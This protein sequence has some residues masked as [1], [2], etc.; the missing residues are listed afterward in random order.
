MDHAVRLGRR[1]HVLARPGAGELE[2]VAHDPV[3]AAAGEDASPGSRSLASVPSKLRPPTAEYSPSLFSR[4]TMKSMSPG[5]RSASGEWMPGISRTGRMLA[6]CWKLAPDRDQQPPERMLSGTPGSRPRR[7]RSA[8][9]P[10]I[11]SSPSS[12]I[13][14]P[15]CEIVI[16]APGQLVPLEAR[17]RTSG[18]PPR[19]R[20]CPRAPPPCRCRRRQSLRSCAFPLAFLHDCVLAIPGKPVLPRSE[21]F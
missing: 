8:S 14:R 12:G 2:G 5:S 13:M 15:C 6:Y 20:G 17:C 16:A 4:T 18:P 21:I 19:A 1:G 11:W 7:G 10:L 3:D 9:C